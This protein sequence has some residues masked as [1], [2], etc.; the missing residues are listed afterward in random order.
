MPTKVPHQANGRHAKS[1]DPAT[2]G[3]FDELHAVY[4][5]GG[6]DGIGLVFSK[7]D[8][9]FGIDLDGCRDSVTGAIDECALSILARFKTYAEV[10]PSGTGVKLF[11]RGRLPID[12]SGAI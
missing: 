6:Y 11:A 2:W 7:D 1:D 10:C 8:D 9:L 5:A 3:S 4:T 12:G